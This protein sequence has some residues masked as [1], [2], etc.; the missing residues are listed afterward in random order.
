MTALSFRPLGFRDLRYAARSL[1][2][3]PWYAVTAAGVIALGISLSTTVFAIVD[4]ALFKP[5]PYRHSDR[6]FAL[7][8]GYSRLAEPL[9]PFPV[10][11]P[12]DVDRWRNA[13]PGVRISAFSAG[14]LQTIG[15]HETIR[16]ARIDAAFFDVVGMAPAIG[17]FVPGD[18]TAS[19]GI[20]PALLSDRLWRTRFG[21]D[22]SVV[23]RTFV[24]R[25]E[26]GRGIRV[27]G[28]L[29]PDFV[30]PFP[31]GPAFVP[32][33]LTPLVDLMP[34][35]QGRNESILVRLES[36]DAAIDASPRF[37]AIVASEAMA[38][39]PVP[40]RPGVPERLRILS[41]GYDRASLVPIR[42]ALTDSLRETSWVAFAAGGCLV[43]LACLNVIG[44]TVA[45]IRGRWRD[46][47]VRSALG[48]SHFDLVR[49]LAAESLLIAGAGAML[50]I[51][52]AQALLPITVQWLTGFLLALK[53]PVIDGRVAA[54][55][56]SVAGG[57]LLLITAVSARAAA[58]AAVR[59]A[60]ADGGAATASDRWGR[61]IIAFEVALALIVAVGGALVAGSLMRVWHED[62]GFDVHQTAII[63]MAAPRGA[64]AAD[65]EQL[66]ADIDRI[67]GVAHAGGVA[68][69]IL[70]RG[71]NGSAFDRPPG[72]AERTTALPI[73][74]IPITRGYFAAAGL[75]P[76]DGRLPTDDELSSGAHVIA[77]SERVARDY[78]PGKR[79]TGETLVND[80]RS[81]VVVGVVPDV[82][83][84]SLDTDPSGE[85]YWAVA[86]SPRPYVS[87]V[88]LR[89]DEGAAL[90]PIAAQVVRGCPK[91][92]VRSARMLTDALGSSIRRRQFNA[93]L[94][95]AF[96]VAALVIVGTGILGLVAMTTSRRTREIGI[97]MAL[98]STQIGVMRQ[99][100][101]EQVLAV[102]LGIAAGG[103]AAAVLTRFLTSYLYKTPVY[104][105]WSWFGA[106]VSLLLITLVGAAIP[107]RQ[108]TRVD[109]VRALRV[110]S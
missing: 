49:L 5:L 80:G 12:A 60:M 53:P 22:R 26:T 54:Y 43:L 29:P 10:V 105:P 6:L 58:G 103:A 75:R 9:R 90:A 21:G 7:G 107:S 73:E 68:H 83:F 100:V 91:C 67:P 42:D 56:A 88:L 97:R 79:A 64:S 47:A 35:S 2:R 48:A 95:S 74:S 45:R 52:G 71:F 13:V 94:F 1:R 85:I 104:D 27:A 20:T 28:V 38:R 18:F 55:A 30:F 8:L 41:A 3:T 69:L 14:D 102:G 37:D 57:C 33:L 39:P 77:V 63:S 109:P 78:W 62:P 101:R 31:E 36:D 17:G 106:I 61:A 72:I 70:E 11:S 84:M 15:T 93:W 32:Q 98:G 51:L 92:W 82:R 44:L 50:G 19:S 99:I 46:L 40:E 65:I 25:A 34:R 59:S 81:F 86:A 24:D 110:E 76:V 96:G 108:A 89:L 23:G 66:I 87:N 4:G 16:S